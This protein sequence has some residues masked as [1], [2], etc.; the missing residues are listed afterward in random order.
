MPGVNFCLLHYFCA[1]NQ[2]RIS[3]TIQIPFPEAMPCIYLYAWPNS[4]IIFYGI[5][6]TNAFQN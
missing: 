1:E 6:K 3:T 5:V 2:N 4:G